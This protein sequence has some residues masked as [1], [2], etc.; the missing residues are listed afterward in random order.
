MNVC[1]YESV[2]TCYAVPDKANG[3]SLKRGF[4]LSTS[5]LHFLGPEKHSNQ[6][7]N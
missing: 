1:Y 6:M 7:L 2:F 4:Y 5:I 3:L